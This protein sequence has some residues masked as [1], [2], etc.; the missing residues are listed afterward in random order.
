[1]VIKIQQRFKY[2]VASL[3]IVIVAVWG[4]LNPQAFINLWLT[5][6]QQGA[7]LFSNQD[8][9]LAADKF[10]DARWKAYSLYAIE[11]FELAGQLWE[12]AGSKKD[13]FARANAFAHNGE[14]FGA[15]K[16]Y[17]ELLEFDPENQDF[18][19]NL[20]IVSALAQQTKS[21]KSKPNK[22]DSLAMDDEQSNP[23]PESEEEKQLGIPVTI[24]TDEMWLEQVKVNPSFFLQKKFAL[25]KKLRNSVAEKVE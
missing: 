19:T 23:E 12:Y 18:I 21:D 4:Y 6:D 20:E 3:T 1:M 14:Y 13:M 2:I 15:Q 11:E 25:E 22:N 7:L 8:Y 9:D 17:T 24:P 5:P 16:I 10:T